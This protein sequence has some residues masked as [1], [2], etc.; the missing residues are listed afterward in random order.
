[1][2]KR[3]ELL[4]FDWDGTLLESAG[5]IVSSIQSACADLGLPV[6]EEAAARHIIGLG[7]RDALGTLLP[8]LPEADYGPLVERYRH[9]FLARDQGIPLFEG[10]AQTICCL[11][12]AGFLLAVATGKSRQGLNRAL[13][14]TGLA[15]YFHASR[16]ADECHSKPHPSM[17]EEIMDE[18][19]AAPGRTLMIGDTTHD[20][21]MA[22]NAGVASLAVAYGAHPRESLEALAPVATLNSFAELRQWLEANA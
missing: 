20:L 9:H 14:Y 6:P 15:Q 19:T 11:S 1:M 22:A 7:L 13:A 21:L 5:P 4:V 10:A 16:C 2:P 18:L 17:L 8:E 12:D 3:F